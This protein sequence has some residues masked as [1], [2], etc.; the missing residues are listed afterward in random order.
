[1]LFEFETYTVESV[2]RGHPDKLCDQISDAILDKCLAGDENSRVAIECMGAHGLLVIGGEVTTNTEFVAEE[3]ARK[4]YKYAGY[5]DKLKIITDIVRQSPDIAMG[6]ASGGAGDQGI[7]YGYA[8][9]ET[10][11]YMPL[12]VV[13]AH[14]LARGLEKLRRGGKADWLM[15]D[16]KTQ[17]TVSNGHI[18]KVLVSC[19]HKEGV[20]QKTIRR[21]L[22]RELIKPTVG[23]L[24][25]KYIL[26]NPTG[27]FV[28]GG[29]SADTGLTG[30]KIMVDTYGGLIPHGGGCFS[31]KDATKVDRSGAY[32]ARFVAKNLVRMGLGEKCLVSVSYAIGKA[33][34]LMVEAI[35]EKG[36]NL[37]RHARK[38]DFRPLSIINNLDLRKPVYRKTSTYGHFGKP[39]FSWERL[40]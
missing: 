16:G 29:F 25:E 18:R 39:Q 3:I 24:P 34:P 14:K 21:I 11:E 15:P 31:G 12:G 4:V 27:Q 33:N 13:L 7:M 20:S 38:F 5:T 19:Q 9:N 30:R 6:V 23:D 40:F 32:M 26:T 37:G 2:T 35:N 8:T 28:N 17:V 10:K 22:I 36:D 1:M